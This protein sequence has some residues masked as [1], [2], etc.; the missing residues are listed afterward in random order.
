LAQSIEQSGGTARVFPCDLTDVDAVR[1]LT[2]LVANDFRHVHLLVNN[3]GKSAW[4][5]FP[6]LHFQEDVK[7]MLDLNVAAS[8]LVI[9]YF[10]ALLPTK[11]GAIVNVASAAGLQGASGMTSYSASKGAVIAMTRSFAIELAP[12][13]IRVNAVAPGV[14][15]TKS[16]ELVLAVLS[17]EQLDAVRARHPLGFGKPQDVANAVAFL[18]SDEASW[19]T[20][21]TL[22]VD[23][24]L[25]A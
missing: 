4:S 2:R 20:G 13:R 5:P 16:T 25:T 14:L 10:A 3:A 1:A 19:I 8:W 18:G 24:G 22:V 12:R 11:R 23:G 21:H 17:Q 15:E 9:R 7:D 6:V